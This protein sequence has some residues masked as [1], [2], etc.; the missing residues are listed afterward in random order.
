MNKRLKVIP[1]R[2]PVLWLFLSICLFSFLFF[3]AGVVFSQTE[4]RTEI[5]TMLEAI[6][7]TSEKATAQ[8]LYIQTDKPNYVTGDTLWF[9]SYTLNANYLNNAIAR[10]ILYIEVVDEN[11][12]LVKRQL[13]AQYFGMCWGSIALNESDYKPGNYLL[14]A[15]TNWMRNFDTSYFFEKPFIISRP[16]IDG[17]SAKKDANLEK[18]EKKIQSA[19]AATE[20]LKLG[21]Y[22]DLQFLPEA[23]NLILGIKSKVGFKAIAKNG[24][25][26]N[27][28]GIV[29]NN[30]QQVVTNF[31]STHL[32]MGSFYLTPKSG[33]TYTAIVNQQS[34]SLPQAKATGITFNVINN[35]LSDSLTIDIMATPDKKNNNFFFIGESRGIGCYG[36]LIKVSDSLKKIKISKTLFP[37]GIIR[38]TLLDEQKQVVCERLVFNK[39]AD[40]LKINIQP[41]KEVYTKRDSVALTVKVSDENGNPVRGGFSLAVTDDNQVKIDSFKNENLLSRILLTSEL[42]GH[43]ED[44]GY[45]FQQVTDEVWENL[46]HLLLTQGWVNY[47]WVAKYHK[48]TAPRFKHE[49]FYGVNGKVTNVFNKPLADVNVV[50]LSKNPSLLLQAR[51][52]NNGV[53]S[54]NNLKP[55]DSAVYFVQARN[56]NNKSFNVGIKIDEFIP[57][58]INFPKNALKSWFL[59]PDTNILA[60]LKTN[61]STIVEPRR[62]QDKKMLKEVVIIGKKIIKDSNNLNGEGEADISLNIDDMNKAGK[63]TLREILFENIPGFRLDQRRY[64]Y[65]IREQIVHLIID[66]VAINAFRPR[67]ISLKEYVENYMDFINAEDIKGVEVMSS[68][69]MIKNYAHQFLRP[70]DDFDA[71]AFIEITTYSGNGAFMNKT[72]GVYLFRP[73]NF[74]NA[75]QFYSPKYS[76]KS[77]LEATDLRSTVYWNPNVV[78][79]KNGEANIEFYTTDQTGSYTLIF[80]GSNTNGYLGSFKSKIVVK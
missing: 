63:K 37:S 80:E 53:F 68:P 18:Q 58:I 34:Y 8:K 30:H 56:K 27:V 57:P 47:N 67:G 61:T 42:K 70:M 14:R 24:L 3:K 77:N 2:K 48:T 49:D 40:F 60:E 26:V 32:G 36:G 15:Y 54:F 66:G 12:K 9:K 6:T 51:T 52:N 74:M 55:A 46:D 69:G 62:P 4:K 5:V 1:K 50:L 19:A 59:N 35:R 64:V 72:P 29:Y 31:K 21:S 10:E 23:G 76:P 73:L 78:T 13:V 44:P 39:R 38:F 17:L 20:I 33:E 75:Q 65:A 45:Y 28:S 43:I 25:G 41:Q 16:A 22:I 11:L 71:H 7:Q 79:D